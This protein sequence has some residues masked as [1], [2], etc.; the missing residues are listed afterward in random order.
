[1][2]ALLVTFLACLLCETGGAIQMLATGLAG[3]NHSAGLLAVGLVA[4]AIAHAALAAVGGAWLAGLMAA[5]ARS[6]FLAIALISGGAAILLPVKQPDM[7]DEWR[8]GT[9]ATAFLGFVILGFG[10]AAQ[11]IVMGMAVRT[12]DPVWAATGGALGTIVACL[13][14]LMVKDGVAS[15]RVLRHV[16]RA[17]GAG[18]LLIG[19]LIGLSALH[20]L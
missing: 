8:I 3:R 14:S 18:L 4:A 11:F 5:D 1:M 20:L 12:A 7:L 15:F 16:R 17:G 6:L 9:L 19:A 2:D 13:P 10:N